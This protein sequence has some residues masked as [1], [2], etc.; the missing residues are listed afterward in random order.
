[1]TINK[2]IV[3]GLGVFLIFSIILPI[4]ADL[5]SPRKQMKTGILAEEVICRNGLDLVIRT[6]GIPSCVKPETVEIMQQRSML[7]KSE[8]STS[9]SQDSDRR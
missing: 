5:E 9:N 3:L 4:H 6:N 2:K 1:M 8:F 7:I